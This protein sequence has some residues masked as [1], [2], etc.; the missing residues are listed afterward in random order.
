V[1]GRASPQEML[2]LAKRLPPLI[3]HSRRVRH[4]ESD[5]GKSPP[6]FSSVMSA[7]WPLLHEQAGAL[8]YISFL[9]GAA[10]SLKVPRLVARGMEAPARTTS[11]FAILT[12]P[13]L[14]TQIESIARG[15]SLHASNGEP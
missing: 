7:V 8:A 12:L 3:D 5:I 15:Y 6:S 9:C 13:R 4:N 14:R 10:K 1:Y 11:E 2:S